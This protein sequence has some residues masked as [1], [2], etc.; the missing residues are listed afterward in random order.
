[1]VQAKINS[2]FN[3]K[4]EYYTIKQGDTLSVLAKTYKTTVDNLVSLNNIKDKNK[5][6]VGQ[7]IRVK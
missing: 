1:M 6:Y 2:M 7:K 4:Q 5:I 3:N